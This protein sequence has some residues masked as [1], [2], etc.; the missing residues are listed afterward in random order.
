[1]GSHGSERDWVWGG[2]WSENTTFARAK[3][4]WALF[5]TLGFRNTLMP[6]HLIQPPVDSRHAPHKVTAMQPRPHLA[7]DPGHCSVRKPSALHMGL[8][9]LPSSRSTT[10][11]WSIVPICESVIRKVSKRERTWC[12]TLPRQE[13]NGGRA[14]KQ[15]RRKCMQTTGPLLRPV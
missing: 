13:V 5:A 9:L 4:P 2:G 6:A 8:R 14:E 7:N 10:N 15:I 3:M 12:K 1:M 11:F